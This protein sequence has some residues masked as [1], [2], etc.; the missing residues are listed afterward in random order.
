[1]AQTTT[2][3]NRHLPI[4]LR[5]LL[6]VIL[7]IYKKIKKNWFVGFQQR[8]FTVWK[9]WK[10]KIP[11]KPRIISRFPKKPRNYSR[12]L[13]KSRKCSRSTNLEDVRGCLKIST[14]NLEDHRGCLK[15]STGNL[16]NCRGCHSNLENIRSKPQKNLEVWKKLRKTSRNML[17]YEAQTSFHM[18][19]RACFHQNLARTLSFHVED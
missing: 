6:G 17:F 4:Y 13:K 18:E 1:M 8:C 11:Q 9:G 7:T 12:F 16:E 5:Y 19:A 14:R 10:W 2:H 15:T 3:R